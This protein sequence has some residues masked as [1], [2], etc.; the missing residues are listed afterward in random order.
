MLAAIGIK[1]FKSVHNIPL[2]EFGRVS[3]FIGANGSGKSN[4]LEA[5]GMLSAAAEG[6]VHADHLLQRGVRHSLPGLYKTSLKG[7]AQSDIVLKASGDGIGAKYEVSLK[8]TIADPSEAWIYDWEKLGD[9]IIKEPFDNILTEHLIGK[10]GRFRSYI[11]KSTPAAKLYTALAGYKI[12]TP[13]TPV[14]RGIQPDIM[15]SDPLGL[16]GGRLAEAVEEI[17]DLKNK[18]F[19]KSDLDEVLDLLYWVDEF[20]ITAPSRELLSP[21][22]PSLRSLVRF[23]DCWM[24][25]RRNLIS[26][27]DASEGAL[28]VLFTLVLALHPRTP[29]FFAVDNFCHSMNPRLSR[30]LARLFCRLML[31]SDPPRQALL[32]TH[33]PLVLDGLDLRDERIRLFAVDRS[34]STGGATNVSRVRLSDSILEKGEKGMPLS[35]MWSMGFLGGVPDIF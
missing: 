34:H 24:D 7:I 21:F 33:S 9:K 16:L 1:G 31:E 28:Y 8:D 6:F 10:K 19:G 22:V 30:G 3:V 20:D 27:Y 2:L 11:D 12:F 25:P 4:L 14:L 23:R 26:G 18:R 15:P 32:T 29:R 13:T 5:V 17:L 35:T